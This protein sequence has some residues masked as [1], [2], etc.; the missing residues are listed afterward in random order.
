MIGNKFTRQPNGTYLREDGDWPG[1]A[2]AQIEGENQR[3]FGN[4]AHDEALAFLEGAIAKNQVRKAW[5]AV[6]PN[7]E[8]KQTKVQAEEGTVVAAKEKKVKKRQDKKV[9]AQEKVAVEI[10][11]R[12]PRKQAET[13]VAVAHP[14]TLDTDKVIQMYKNSVKIV[15]IA[16][17]FGY[18]R[19]Q[20][21]NKIRAILREAKVYNTPTGGAQATSVTN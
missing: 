16:V 3:A 1:G 4:Y 5:Y 18:A 9:V 8:L 10:A 12:K 20:G 17:A 15:D 19:G 7:A 2:R 13:P 6:I 11:T 21:Q 14:G